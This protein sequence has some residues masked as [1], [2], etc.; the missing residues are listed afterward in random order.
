MVTASTY[1]IADPIHGRIELSSA[2]R[3]LLTARP[4]GRLARIH[5]LSLMHLT[6]RGAIHSRLEHSLGVLDVAS[7]IFD[8]ITDPTRLTPEVRRMLSELSDRDCVTYWRQVVRVAALCHDV[9]H[10]PFSHAAENAVLPPGW[11]HEHLTRAV[12]LDDD[13]GRDIEAMGLRRLDVAKL[14]IGPRAWPAAAF[15]PWEKILSE[16]ISANAF[17]A[18]RI[19]YLTRDPWH[20]GVRSPRFDAR[21]L[22]AALRIL[23]VVRLHAADGRQAERE[24]ALGMLAGGLPHAGALVRTRNFMF[25]RVF[26]HHTRCSYDIHFCDF[27][28]AW[29]PGRQYPLTVAQHV[30]TDDV[31]VTAACR[32]AAKNPRSPG[33]DAARRLIDR[34]PFR[35]LHQ[36]RF[37][38]KRGSIK[39]DAAIYRATAGRFGAANVRCDTR[40]LHSGSLT[41]PVR[42]ATRQVVESTAAS[43]SMAQQPST[44]IERIFIDPRLPSMAMRRLVAHGDVRLACRGDSGNR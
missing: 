21:A 44:R 19:D 36:A 3:E 42:L 20:L 31:Q 35:L 38:T 39:P 16:I 7:R 24:P 25:S 6:H 40:V 28:R 18:D 27:L 13:L 5:Q 15:S 4:L 29:L 41:F 22:I 32:E 37:D 9:G 2:E 14:A 26:Y 33:H 11:T 12:I 43:Q 8:A 34:E 30:A 17:G 23:P 10:L 1:A